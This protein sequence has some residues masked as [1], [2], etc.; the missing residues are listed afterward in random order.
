MQ[1]TNKSPISTNGLHLLIAALRSFYTMIRRGVFDPQDQ[2]FHPLYAYE[3]PMYSK[4][5]EVDP[6]RWSTGLR[7]HPFR[8][9]G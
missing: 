3:N 8:I 2:R 9:A 4:V 6:Q 5:L 7:R 1:A